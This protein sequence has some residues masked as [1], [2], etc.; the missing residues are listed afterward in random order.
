MIVVVGMRETIA[1]YFSDTLVNNNSTRFDH[2]PFSNI[3]RTV[4]LLEMG[5]K[6][7]PCP[8][9]TW[10]FGFFKLTIRPALYVVPFKRRVDTY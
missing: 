3:I 10:Q 4:G 1:G 2:V 8:H 9:F 5:E 7:M 6:N